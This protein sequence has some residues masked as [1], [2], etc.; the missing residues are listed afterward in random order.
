LP[1][2]SRKE[3][4]SPKKST[5]YKLVIILFIIVIVSFGFGW[6]LSENIIIS[7]FRQSKYIRTMAKGSLMPVYNDL[8]EL[9][10]SLYNNDSE[11]FNQALK[12]LKD[13]LYY[14]RVYGEYLTSIGVDN[15][16]SSVV[17]LMNQLV[18]DLREIGFNKVYGLY[19]NN[20]M[21]YT[22]LMT[23]YNAFKDRAYTVTS[24]GID[25]YSDLLFIR[26]INRLLQIIEA[27]S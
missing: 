1:K 2:K 18:D 5:K 3:N 11:L 27:L 13:D 16:L 10:Q 21:F 4:R 9:L 25:R 24:I 8:D 20:S 22:N 14:L 23:L 17:D 19:M 26:T 7:R 15:N 12:D 6:F